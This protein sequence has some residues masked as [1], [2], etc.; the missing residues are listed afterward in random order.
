[1][2][3]AILEQLKNESD[4]RLQ[5]F[6]EANPATYV[7]SKLFEAEEPFNGSDERTRLFIFSNYM[8]KSGLINLA[9]IITEEWKEE[10]EDSDSLETS[11]NVRTSIFPLYLTKTPVYDMPEKIESPDITPE[12]AR[13]I[14]EK[15]SLPKMKMNEAFDPCRHRWAVN[16]IAS[17]LNMSNRLVAQ[18]IKANNL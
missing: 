6:L 3:Y 14:I 17:E 12:R 4:E 15:R 1:M 2:E 8:S 9:I 11:S 10:K 13:F 5:R 7:V 16:K 18:Y